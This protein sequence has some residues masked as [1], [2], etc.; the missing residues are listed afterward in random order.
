MNFDDSDADSV[1]SGASRASVSSARDCIIVAV[2]PEDLAVAC[3]EESVFILTS[4]LYNTRVSIEELITFAI[5]GSSATES[6]MSYNVS[7]LSALMRGVVYDGVPFD[8]QVRDIPRPVVLSEN[9]VVVRVTTAAICGSDLH[10][11]RG[12]MGGNPPW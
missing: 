2:D 6:T 11:Y 3:T 9:E 12:Y 1:A 7:C 10:V 8:M 4:K 5:V